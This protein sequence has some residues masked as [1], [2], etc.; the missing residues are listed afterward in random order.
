MKKYPMIAIL[1]FAALAL[2]GCAEGE[3]QKQP[4]KGELNLEAPH[5]A[6]V[7]SD[8]LDINKIHY[9]AKNG[10]GEEVSAS[11]TVELNGTELSGENGKYF[12]PEGGELVIRAEAVGL[13]SELRTQV[14]EL[15]GSCVADAAAITEGEGYILRE[16]AFGAYAEVTAEQDSFHAAL[17]AAAN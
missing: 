12:L 15:P 17:Y 1:L 3:E 2:A 4:Q 5:G 16:D 10:D 9:T 14:F 7:A 13:E 11:F 6:L 8:E